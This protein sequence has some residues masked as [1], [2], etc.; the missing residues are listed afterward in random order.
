MKELE[1]KNDMKEDYKETDLLMQ[2][3]KERKNARNKARNKKKQTLECNMTRVSVTEMRK[4][5][6]RSM[7][8][9]AE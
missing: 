6:D 4:K 9:E 5:R 2:G 7:Q 1:G 8:V 3:S